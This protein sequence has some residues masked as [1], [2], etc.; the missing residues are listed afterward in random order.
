MPPFRV[1]LVGLGEAATHLHLP[2]L[3]GLPEATIV[4]AADLDSGRRAAVAKGWNVPTFGDVDAMLAEARPEV[5]I[6]GTPPHRHA[7]VC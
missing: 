6:V 1:A 5:V 4:G 2:A 7:D 3:A